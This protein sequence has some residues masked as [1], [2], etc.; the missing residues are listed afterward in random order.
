MSSINHICKKINLEYITQ[1]SSY[2]EAQSI[3]QRNKLNL[4]SIDNL[5]LQTE[6]FKT[7]TEKLKAKGMIFPALKLSTSLDL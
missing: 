1:V 7:I 3:C 4:V 6:L 5:Y 2:E